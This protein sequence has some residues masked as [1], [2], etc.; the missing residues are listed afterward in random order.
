LYAAFLLVAATCLAWDGACGNPGYWVPYAGNPPGGSYGGLENGYDPANAAAWAV[1]SGPVWAPWTGPGGECCWGGYGSS[2][3]GKHGLTHRDEHTHRPDSASP[4]RG[5]AG[6]P[7]DSCPIA[8]PGETWSGSPGSEEGGAPDL[9][10]PAVAPAGQ[11]P[12]APPAGGE[13]K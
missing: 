7:C 8:G 9:G 11:T 4:Q 2:H 3:G 5:N 1:W 12:H 13:K 10:A 6:V